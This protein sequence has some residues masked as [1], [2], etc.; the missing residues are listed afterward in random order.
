MPKFVPC[1]YDGKGEQ[2]AVVQTTLEVT[3]SVVQNMGILEKVRGDGGGDA[4]LM[5]ERLFDKPGCMQVSFP[6]ERI[7]KKRSKVELAV[8]LAIAAN[9]LLVHECFVAGSVVKADKIPGKGV[10]L[11]GAIRPSYHRKLGL[12]ANHAGYH[13]AVLESDDNV[14]AGEELA[15][16]FVVDPVDCESGLVENLCPSFKTHTELVH[17][18]DGGELYFAENGIAKDFGEDILD[19]CQA[20]VLLVVSVGLRGESMAE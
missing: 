15:L 6:V 20:M 10:A 4:E 17:A 18:A 12:F 9:M 7:L 3:Y 13:S 16:E 19:L 5:S 11:Y 14:F 1:W 2:P 8:H